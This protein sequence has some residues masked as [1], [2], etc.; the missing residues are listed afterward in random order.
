MDKKD[1]MLK[2]YFI[3]E[4]FA[5]AINAI[6]YNGKT[7]VTP[8]Q[9]AR[10]EK[11]T[12]SVVEDDNEIKTF[13]RRRDI[14]NT[15]ELEDAIYCM[16]GIENQ[17]TEDYTM[18]L[19]VMEYDVRNY[20]QQIKDAARTEEQTKTKVKVKL[21][22]IITIVMY[23]KPSQWKEAKELKDMFDEKVFS[24]MQANGMSQFI[25]NYKMNLFEPASATREDLDKFKTELKDV[26]AY[27]KYSKNTDELK[28]YNDIYKP[29]LSKDTINLINVITN[30]NYQFQE[31]KETLDMCEAFEGIKQ[32]GIAE[33]KAEGIAEGKA[34]GRAEGIA[35][36]IAVGEYKSWVTAA[37][38][39]EK[40]GMNDSEI[41]AILGISEM[42]LA[43]AFEYV[44]K[45]KEQNKESS[46]T[47]SITG[48]DR[49]AE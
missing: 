48:K 16:F 22:P 11:E 44:E 9:I 32:E 47:I 37:N 7:V 28:K 43:E 4:R 23:W 39:M 10:A 17:S 1:V 24:W 14:I 18:P 26:I 5:D 36:G 6:V 40:R 34:E 15:V 19:R 3:A 27:V 31:G 30:S 25:Q 38:N 49:E 29:N 41:A 45:C 42:K 13:T 8:E 12:H 35:E 21:K 20:M 2:E 33:G 46:K